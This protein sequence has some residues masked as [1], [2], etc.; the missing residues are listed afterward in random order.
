MK[1]N[2]AVVTLLILFTACAKY[3]LEFENLLRLED[4]REP[5]EKFAPSVRHLDEQVQRRAIQ[6]LGKIQDPA[7]LRYLLPLLDHDHQETRAAAAFAIGQ[8]GDTTAT[9]ALLTRLGK[10]IH[11]LVA[12]SL[13]EALGKAGTRSVLPVMARNLRDPSPAWRGESALALARLAGRNIKDPRNASKLATALRDRDASVRSAAAYALI[14]CGDST[15][16]AQ[17]RA[18][19]RDTSAGVRMNAV[20]ALGAIGDPSI[21]LHL[22]ALAKHDAD[23]RVRVNATKALGN[24]SLPSIFDL[25]PINDVDEHVRLSALAALGA[26]ASR[27]EQPVFDLAKARE[28]DF[29]REILSGVQHSE[30]QQHTWREYAAAALALVQSIRGEAVE[31]LSPFVH[32]PRPLFRAQ[33]AH[34]LA[35]TNDRRAFPLMQKLAADS[36]LTVRLAAVEALPQLKD[37]RATQTYLNALFSGDQVLAATA[38]QNLAADS[39]QRLKYLPQMI[40]AYRL[41]KPPVDVEVAQIMFQSLASCGDASVAPILEEALRVPDRVFARAALAPLK[42][43]TGRDYSRHLPQIASPQ[44]HWTWNDIKNLSGT[45]ATIRTDR[46][47][48]D[49][50][51]FPD[52][53]PLTVLN[54]VRLA[55][56]N[57]FDGL[58]IHRVEPNFVIQAGDPRGDEWGSPGYTIR[59]EFNALRYTRGAVGMASSGPDTEGSQFF[60]VHSDQPHLNGRYTVFARVTHGMEVVDALQVGDVIED[61]VIHR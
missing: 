24:L 54:F 33:L 60:I 50:E 28:L 30:Q 32:S 52:E 35:A 31:I 37:R 53:A 36:S 55:E 3:D 38:M 34:A 11:P 4:R 26:S 25:L 27:Q 2:H 46:G 23:W 61:V 59:S 51:F 47:D 43:L 49:M 21:A 40:E 7:G 42:T 8:I 56:K 14:R 57:F 12:G 19:L 20:R 18:A 9:E 22:S 10:E 5:A 44:Q 17:L 29:L 45:S 13:I 39:L 1:I 58:L 6:A 15:V 41:L 48:I 16:V